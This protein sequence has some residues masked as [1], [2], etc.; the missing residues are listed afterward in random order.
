M[1]MDR[2]AGSE[3]R[4]ASEDR[5][6]TVRVRA[7]SGYDVKIGSGLLAEAG[8]LSREV[9]RADKIALFTDAAV[10]ALY[11]DR[12]EESLRASGF[13]T[14]RF[15]FPGGE[16]SKEI[17]TVA[18]FVDFMAEQH[19]TRRDAVAALGGG[20]VGDMGGFA[21]SVYL[22]GVDF[23]QIPTTLLAAV[24]SSVGGK[25]GVN[26]AAGK[27]LMGAFWQPS[28]VL[29]DTDTFASLNDDLILDGTAEAVKTAAIRDAELFRLISANRI[30]DV[31]ME[32]VR[33]CVEIKGAVVDADEKE[34]GLRRI[35]N[36][37]HT[38]AHAIEKASDYGISHGKAVAAGMVMMTAASEAAGMT[39]QGTCDALR[40][41]LL[42]KGFDLNQ[43]EAGLGRLCRLAAS[44]KKTLGDGISL[45]YLEKIGK[46]SIYDIE[47]SRLEAFLS[48]GFRK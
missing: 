12:L 10:D 47:L 36:F 44:D 43:G 33:R 16:A 1:E 35:L 17:G 8:R 20:V 3:S 29:Y 26:I 22:R 5:T 7:G 23:I 48:D 19:L 11:G 14:C 15:V 38:M 40:K 2:R 6:E 31:L 13:E 41:A 28:L 24:D 46:S 4:T 34:G 21:A 39:A 30:G 42:D 25:T 9:L 45:V 37:G 27:N 32:V 18:R